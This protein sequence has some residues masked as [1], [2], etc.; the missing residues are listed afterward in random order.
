[1]KN[2]RNL[3]S[4]YKQINHLPHLENLSM[5]GIREKILQ[6]ILR[7]ESLQ[8][9]SIFIEKN[10]QEDIEDYSAYILLQYYMAKDSIFVHSQKTI[11]HSYMSLEF[12]RQKADGKTRVNLF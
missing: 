10:L 9:L 7:Y 1:M 6:F 11:H 5:Q 2:L 12:F 3:Q 4:S 8:N